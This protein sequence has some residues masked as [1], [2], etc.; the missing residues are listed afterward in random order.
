MGKADE[1]FEIE[2]LRVLEVLN[3]P[4]RLRIFRNLEEPKTVR[5]VADAMAVPVTRLYYHFGM[6][7]DV[8]VIEVV[9]TRKVGAMIEK[10]YQCV[11]GTFRPSPNLFLKTDDPGRVARASANV[12][13]DGARLDAEYGLVRHFEAI[14]NG[15]DRA[16]SYPGTI[17]RSVRLMTRQEA[18]EFAS[19]LEEL[20][21]EWGHSTTDAD[22]EGAEDYTLS[23]VF[24]PLANPARD[25]S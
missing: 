10:L 4:T 5:E 16:E 7:Q 11:A 2:D 8:G 17:S 3:S 9:E 6:L 24:F 18:S 20:V 12:V 19:R 14:A 23:I 25:K 22:V 15:Q 1:V 21:A 13:L